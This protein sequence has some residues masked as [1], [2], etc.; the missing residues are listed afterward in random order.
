M[1]TFKLTDARKVLASQREWYMR[2]YDSREKDLPAG[3]HMDYAE[4]FGAGEAV[5]RSQKALTKAVCALREDAFTSDRELASYAAAVFV[6]VA[7]NDESLFDEIV[8]GAVDV[9]VAA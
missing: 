1:V 4:L 2:M 3:L 9:P 6:V 8:S 7:G 5:A